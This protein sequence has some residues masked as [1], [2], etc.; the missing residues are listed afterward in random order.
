[1]DTHSSTVTFA[2]KN[3][4]SRDW[5]KEATERIIREEVFRVDEEAEERVS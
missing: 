3:S 1:M 2:G 4:A 5:L